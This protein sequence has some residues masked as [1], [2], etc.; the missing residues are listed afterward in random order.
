MTKS[1]LIRLLY[2]K[3][4]LLPQKIISKAVDLILTEI[5][6]GVAE[7]KPVEIRG[8]G[9]FSNRKR[10]AKTLRHPA[11]SKMIKVAPYNAMHYSYSAK[12]EI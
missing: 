10:G 6:K 7:Q 1:Q 9:Q 5:S 3:N 11:T 4:N 8:F 2:Y 12:L